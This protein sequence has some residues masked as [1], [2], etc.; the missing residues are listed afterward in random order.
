MAT[1]EA[2]PTYMWFNIFDAVDFA[3]LDE[4]S[5][6]LLK[7]MSP[8]EA[9]ICTDLQD[10]FSATYTDAALPVEVEVVDGS[11]TYIKHSQCD[12]T[13]M[14]MVWDIS[15][16]NTLENAKWHSG[17]DNTKVNVA[18]STR[19]YQDSEDTPNTWT[20]YTFES[21][22]AAASDPSGF[23]QVNFWYLGN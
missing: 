10:V 18:S 6:E 1:Y 17:S 14:Y 4:S 11:N 20:V 12:G 23:T 21:E 16:P 22:D 8:A 2:A 13:P 15:T 19:Q 9:D 7:L 3:T 5:T